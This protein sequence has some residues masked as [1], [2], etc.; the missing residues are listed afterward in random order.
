[1][2]RGEGG[3]SRA[4]GW[5]LG[6]NLE[7]L[8]AGTFMVVMCLSTLGNVVARY[9]FGFSIS[10]AEELSRYSFIWLVFLGAA[11]CSKHGRHI[12]I[13]ALV[14]LLP[15]SAQKSC[16]LFVGFAT[17]ALMLVLIYYGGILVASA[18]YPTSTLG[19][20]TYF[21]YLAVPISALLI[22][23]HSLQDLYRDLMTVRG[24]A[25]Q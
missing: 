1:M 14:L 25:Q 12:C 8:V 20:P 19:M 15:S 10:W 18:G 3:P 5:E 24:G 22:L 6:R 13:D 2:G 11:L 16:R 9:V 17:A 23:I 7:E 21:V 4:L